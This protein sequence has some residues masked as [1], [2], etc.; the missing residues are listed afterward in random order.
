MSRLSQDEKIQAH[1][2]RKSL[3]GVFMGLSFTYALVGIFAWYGPGGINA[4]M[5]VQ[6]NMWIVSPI[7]LTIMSFSFMFKTAFTAFRTLL[8]AN[9][10]AYSIFLALR[11]AL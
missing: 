10:I 2:W 3:I 6:F 5:K 4:P 9:I 7:W 11:W 1:W 8:I